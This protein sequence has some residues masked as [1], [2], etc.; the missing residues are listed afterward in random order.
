MESLFKAEL[1]LIAAA[2]QT[3]RK[4]FH[5]ALP[6]NYCFILIMLSKLTCN[7][8]GAFIFFPMQ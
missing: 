8:E 6:G 1:D 3:I 2:S 5:N 7:I 4:L